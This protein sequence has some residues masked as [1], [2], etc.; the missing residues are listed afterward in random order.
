[1]ELGKLNSLLSDKEDLIRWMAE[2]GVYPKRKPFGKL[3]HKNYT[4]SGKTDELPVSRVIAVL[5]I[6]IGED[7]DRVRERITNH[8][9]WA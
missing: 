3:G 5:G 2:H 4:L 6:K 7:C 1:M 9:D 8:P